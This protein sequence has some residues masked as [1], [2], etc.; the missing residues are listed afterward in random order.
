MFTR[1]GF[2]GHEAHYII[3][4]IE[5]MASANLIKRFE[6]KLDAVNTKFTLLLWLIGALFALGLF[7]PLLPWLGGN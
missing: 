3:K 4:S 6:S 2:K 7:G 5:D 1:R